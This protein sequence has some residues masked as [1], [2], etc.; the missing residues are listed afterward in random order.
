MTPAA[1]AAPTEAGAEATADA[2][3][4]DVQVLSHRGVWHVDPLH[5]GVHFRG[6]NRGAGRV[7]GRFD[8]VR[9]TVGFKEGIERPHID[10]RVELG[11]VSTGVAARDRHLRSAD[12]L[13]VAAHP[14]MTFT[15]KRLVRTGRGIGEL[16]GEL[17]LH[18]VTR[19]LV[20]DVEWRGGAP[21]VRPG[22]RHA[23]FGAR[24]QLSLGEYGIRP[25]LLPGLTI[26]GVGDRVG[27]QL[28]VVLVPYDPA[29][30]LS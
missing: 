23:A 25:L 13:D 3:P 10:V 21:D 12:Y 8:R 9:G 17:A 28:D 26:P 15:S 18:G 19:P 16:I 7:R 14:Y 1:Q 30:G 22:A 29:A 2:A 4:V 20:L 24:G 11:S 6:L 27:I 5:T